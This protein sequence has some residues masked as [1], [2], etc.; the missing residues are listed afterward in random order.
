MQTALSHFSSL[1]LSADKLFNYGAAGVRALSHQ[2]AATKAA[3][4]NKLLL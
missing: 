2:A 1:L 4:P 3:D